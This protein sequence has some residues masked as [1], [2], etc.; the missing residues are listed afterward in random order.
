MSRIQR[1]VSRQLKR[2]NKQELNTKDGAPRW[3]S[4]RVPATK[5][6]CTDSTPS[7]SVVSKDVATGVVKHVSPYDK[8]KRNAR[9]HN[10]KHN[11]QEIRQ[12]P[13]QK[14]SLHK[15]PG[16]EDLRQKDKQE[17]GQAVD[18]R[19]TRSKAK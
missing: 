13:R 17:W 10:E 3:R 16:Y 15:V 18:S 12:E 1:Q 14:K 4:C 6:D 11:L 9:S 8:L 7:K 19:H 2:H 5:L